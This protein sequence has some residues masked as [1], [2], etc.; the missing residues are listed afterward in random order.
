M[1]IVVFII[2]SLA[3]LPFGV[4][5]VLADAVY[6]IL[7]FIMR[8]RKGVITENLHLSFPEKSVR[9]IK[10]IRNDF[11][12]NFADYIVE[13][14]KLAHVSEDEIARR[15]TF[16]DTEYL[17]QAASEGKNTV[18]YFSHCFNWEWAPSV[19]LHLPSEIGE[20]KIE[21]CQVYRPLKN[22]GFD[23]LML[24]LRGRFGSLSLKKSSV[25]RDLLSLNREGK[26]WITGF[27]SDQRPSHGDNDLYIPFLGRETAF[28]SG[29]ERVARTFK[30]S[31]IYWD[32]EK[33]SRGHYHITCRPI[34]QDA[35]TPTQGEITREYAQML[36]TTIRRRPGLW[37]WS[38]KRWRA[39]R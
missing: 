24:R 19:T 2:N 11:Y 34:C 22:K 10:E 15:F 35:S 39:P 4:L 37:L 30:A 9:E 17:E 38:H 21:F 13:T 8:Y 3:R 25:L 29:T 16:S 7:R 33:T 36:E 27:M 26:I 14:I 18:I 12:R 5:Y 32:M 23:S 6:F 20:R 31:V 28:I 1:K